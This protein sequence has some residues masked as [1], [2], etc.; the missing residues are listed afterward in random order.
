MYHPRGGTGLDDAFFLATFVGGGPIINAY[1]AE[2][3]DIPQGA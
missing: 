2:Y 3:A 1:G